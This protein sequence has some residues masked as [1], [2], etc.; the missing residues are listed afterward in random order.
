MWQR[1]KIPPKAGFWDG[2]LL[3]N[4][5]QQFIIHFEFADEEHNC[6]SPCSRFGILWFSAGQVGVGLLARPNGRLSYK[7]AFGPDK[8]GFRSAIVRRRKSDFGV[9][10][11]LQGISLLSLKTPGNVVVRI[12][13]VRKSAGKSG[14]AR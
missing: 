4:Y 3:T 11:K 5:Q 8:L 12:A 2:F 10:A 7:D 13:K 14:I 9:F 1:A 6:G